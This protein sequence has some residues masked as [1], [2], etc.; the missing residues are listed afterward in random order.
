MK[1]IS[2]RK[3]RFRF[4]DIMNGCQQKQIVISKRLWA[5]QEVTIAQFHFQF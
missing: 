5:V 3:Q 1:K 4:I 2:K